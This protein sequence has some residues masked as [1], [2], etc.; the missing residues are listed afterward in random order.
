[1]PLRLK[2]RKTVNIA[3]IILASLMLQACGN[4]N[5]E[6]A[7]SFTA[8]HIDNADECH[9]CGM[10]IN[11]FPGPKG[12]LFEKGK[13]TIRK[14]C[15]TVDLFSYAL[16]PDNIH[17]INK[18]L[19][20]DMTNSPWKETQETELID[21]RTAW[22]VADHKLTG[23]MGPTIASFK[24]QSAAES[25]IAKQGGYTLKFSDISTELIL[26]MSQARMAMP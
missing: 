24:T 8:V 15:S 1:M 10:V 18:I 12:E 11:Q 14:F 2:P 16:Q 19:V 3:L 23:A 20:H 5:N 21:A 26:K 7:Q 22:Y 17:N 13:Q 6:E 9:L 4:S 25:F